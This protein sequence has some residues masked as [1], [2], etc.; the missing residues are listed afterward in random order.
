MER[1][2]QKKVKSQKRESLKVHVTD[3][4]VQKFFATQIIKEDK[5]DKVYK[6]LHVKKIVGLIYIKPRHLQKRFPFVFETTTK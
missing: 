6:L 5:Y 2:N 3:A 4:L 1:I